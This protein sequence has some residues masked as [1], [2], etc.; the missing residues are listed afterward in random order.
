[1]ENNCIAWISL[2]TGS[3]VLHPATVISVT[4]KT[5]FSLNQWANV[6]N[7]IGDFDQLSAKNAILTNS[8]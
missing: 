8:R 2:E 6:I 3:V 4:L 7:A 1:V 5:F